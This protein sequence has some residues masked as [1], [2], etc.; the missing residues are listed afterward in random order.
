MKRRPVGTGLSVTFVGSSCLA[1]SPLH[2]DGSHNILTRDVVGRGGKTT[3]SNKA[4]TYN[5]DAHTP[6]RA[7]HR[8]TSFEHAKLVG[9]LGGPPADL[10]S[11]WGGRVFPETVR[12]PS[13]AQPD[14]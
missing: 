4:T 11:L 12:P 3:S 9:H 2:V 14:D 5:C 13:S 6:H 10:A 1:V 7:S 8:K